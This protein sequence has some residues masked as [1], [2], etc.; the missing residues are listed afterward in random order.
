MDIATKTLKL[1]GK[2]NR[3]VK[4]GWENI[5]TGIGTGKDK[6][7]GNQIKRNRTNQAEIEVLHDS[8]D[9]AKLAVNEVPDRGTSKWLK[10][11]IGKKEGGI[12]QV[13]KLVDEDERL[14]LKKKINKAWKWAR[15]YGG[16]A[17]FISVDDGQDLDKPLNINR[18]SRVNSLTVLQ[19]YE[20]QRGNIC[21]DIDSP[22]FGLPDYYQLFSRVAATTQ[23]IHHSR[24]IRFDGMPLSSQEFQ[25]ND[26]WNDSVLNILADIIRDYNGAYAGVSHAMQDFDVSILKLKDLADLVGSDD[27]DLVVG[28]LK[29]MNLAKSVMGSILLDA[30]EEDFQNMSRQFTNVD[31]VL[32]KLDQ[33]LV[34]AMRMPHTIVLGNGSTGTLGAGGESENNNMNSLV[35]AQQDEVIKDPLNF[36]FKIIQ[37]AK[38]GPTNGKILISHSWVF[39][40]LSEPSEKEVAETRKAVSESDKNYFEIGALSSQEIAESR[41]GGDE[42]SMETSV[43]MD[44][45][46]EQNETSEI[47]PDKTKQIMKGIE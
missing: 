13:N 27:D 8:D 32:S 38:Q 6:R 20:L 41:F 30:E 3:F 10:H 47:S 24:I 40:A 36:I 28:R 25:N 16:S 1:G 39:N 37:A 35:S 33:R 42:Y 12:D 46:E 21:D 26:Y 43:D 5:F 22:N 14:Q 31:K 11:S 4:D 17:I 2:F 7:T 19:R 44:S 34:M 18:I 29:L 9:L 45:R 15:L 23:K